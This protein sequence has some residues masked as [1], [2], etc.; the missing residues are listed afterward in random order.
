MPPASRTCNSACAERRRGICD[1]RREVRTPS[2]AFSVAQVG[3]RS[4]A[5]WR[6][7]ASLCWI[8][9]RACAA[10]DIRIGGPLDDVLIAAKLGVF[11]SVVER[12]FLTF[13]KMIADDARRARPP[14]SWL[15]LIAQACSIA[16]EGCGRVVGAKMRPAQHLENACFEVVL[17]DRP[18]I[19]RLSWRLAGRRACRAPVRQTEG[20]CVLSHRRHSRDARRARDRAAHV[21]PGVPRSAAR[22]FGLL[23]QR[24]AERQRSSDRRGPSASRALAADRA[25]DCA[26]YIRCEWFPHS[27]PRRVRRHGGG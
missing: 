1:S 11:E 27:P 25:A 9:T 7:S 23:L 26:A 15:G 22:C 18:G 4:P 17:G 20:S 6:S 10:P 14:R 24:R 8:S 12:F 19:M 2:P 3:F 21:R 5:S 13:R 16:G